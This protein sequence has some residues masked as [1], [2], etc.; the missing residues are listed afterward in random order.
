MAIHF[1]NSYAQQWWNVVRLDVERLFRSGAISRIK[2]ELIQ[3]IQ[4]DRLMLRE[5]DVKSEHKKG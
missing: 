2:A 3:Q 5:S 1:E 4:G